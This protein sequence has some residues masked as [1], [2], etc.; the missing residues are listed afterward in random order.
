MIII[1]TL[2]K[3][4][5]KLMRVERKE[6]S[7]NKVT[8]LLYEIGNPVPVDIRDVKSPIAVPTDQVHNQEYLLYAS[9]FT[10]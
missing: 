3:I 9:H 8:E 7:A 2:R 5:D 10:S 4:G 1:N 6:Y